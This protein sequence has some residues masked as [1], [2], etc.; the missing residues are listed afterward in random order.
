[1]AKRDS[2]KFVQAMEKYIGEQVRKGVAGLYT[3]T[4][5]SAEAVASAFK[6]GYNKLNVELAKDGQELVLS[7]ADFTEVG[8]AGVAAVKAWCEQP[9]T[10]GA[11]RE[12]SDTSVTYV[13]KRD[14]QKPHTLCK[15]A[16]MAVIQRKRTEQGKRKLKGGGVD[17]KTG[18]RIYGAA[19]E[20][21]RVKGYQHKAHQGAT[22]VGAARLAAGMEYISRT[23]DFAGF[24]K[25][26]SAEKLMEIFQEVNIVFSTSGTKAK[27]GTISLNED[28]TI[29]VDVLPRSGNLQGAEKF[30]F[31]NIRPILEQAIADYIEEAN[32]VDLKGSKSIRENAL[33]VAEYN[34]I[35]DIVKGRK[36]RVSGGNKK[37]KGRKKTHTEAGSKAKAPKK[38]RVAKVALV[39]GSKV[40]KAKESNFS[41][42]HLMG[43]LND[44]LPQTVEANMGAPRLVNQSGRFANS[45]R[46]T[47]VSTT[48]QGFPSIGYTYQK[49]PYQTFETGYRQGSENRD[50]RTLIDSS[51]REIAAQFAIGRFYTRRV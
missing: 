25:S 12:V 8:K 48:K 7:E 38:S 27:G 19:S 6:E 4:T 40:A 5:F 51:I 50:P 16:A 24:A 34:V 39:K 29:L 17:Q 10:H 13:S 35:Q 36:A 47:D 46:I 2:K 44:R 18:K 28:Q 49:N 21:G 42:A 9:K 33:E 23:K 11:L 22:T 31:S 14:I 15:Q 43:V 26:K 30:D 20:I 1:M 45:T 41:L 37:P 32:L 3:T